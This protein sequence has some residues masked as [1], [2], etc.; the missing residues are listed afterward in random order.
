MDEQ[1][2]PPPP[3]PPATDAYD[4]ANSERSSRTAASSSARRSAFRSTGAPP[5]PAPSFSQFR[6]SLATGKKL[7]TDDS[8][9][10]SAGF[11]SELQVNTTMSSSAA[12]GADPLTPRSR[13]A[14]EK[15]LSTLESTAAQ[16]SAS[17]ARTNAT[18]S[19]A[20]SSNNTSISHG[21]SFYS[22]ASRAD[23]ARLR[24]DGDKLQPPL[25]Q[26]SPH[27]ALMHR[28]DNVMGTHKMSGVTAFPGGAASTLGGTASMASS[29]TNT[30]AYSGSASSTPTSAAGAVAVSAAA[31]ASAIGLPHRYRK[32][33]LMVDPGEYTSCGTEILYNS[34]IRLRL[35]NHQYLRISAVDAGGS[36]TGG[37]HDLPP[38]HPTS[39]EAASTLSATT[40]TLGVVRTAGP[41]GKAVAIDANG[42]GRNGDDDQVFVLVNASLRTDCGEVH[43]SDTVALYCVA[44]SCKGHFLSTD[45]ITQGVTLKKGPVISNNEKWRLVNPSIPAESRSESGGAFGGT[46]SASNSS[47]QD[48]YIS[49]QSASFLWEQQKIIATSDK[50]MLKMN[51]ADVFLS[52]P[53]SVSS[54]VLP[55]VLR[56]ENDG[57]DDVV[58]VWEITKS[59][60]PFDPEWNREREYLT[61]EAFVQPASKR[62]E[63]AGIGSE[64]NLRPLSTLP[65]SVQE[66]IM[67]DELLYAFVGLEGRY[68]KL[69]VTETKSEAARS[70]RSFKFVLNQPGMDPSISSLASRCFRL[71]EFYLQLS[72][73]VEQFSRYEYGQVNHA[74]CAALKVL[75]KEYTIVI[76]Q[77]EHQMKSSGAGQ[78]HHLT[79]QKMWYQIQP[80]MRTM[81]MLSMLVEACRNTLGGGS[82]LTEIQNMMSSLAGDTKARQVFS[83]LMERA[84]VP[85]LKMIE[86]W[87]Y[88]GDLVDPY[89][90]FM[91]RRDDQIGKE[92]VSDNPYS[93][94]WESRYTIRKTQTPRF[95]TRFEQ[96]ILTA[97]KYLNIF[98]TCNRQVDCPF[99]GPI[100]YSAGEAA[101]EEMIDRAHGYASQMLLDLFLKENDLVNRLS[102]IK[103]YFLMDQ[104]DFF[105]DFMHVAEEELK[106]RA[107]KL[108]LSRLE[109]LLHLSL[110]TSTCASDPYKD[111]LVCFLSPHNLI[112]Q[113]E[114]I[115][116]RAQKG[117]RDS[118][119]TFASSSIGH[120]GMFVH[121]TYPAA[122]KGRAIVLMM[123]WCLLT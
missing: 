90:E 51:T 97:G 122:H 67:M 76:G 82:L 71:G 63:L 92:D 26:M 105:V 2:P 36:A 41:H 81:E 33:G 87:I 111:D 38:R 73:Y 68:V 61:G 57:I 78:D 79:M 96:K 99:A 62:R 14:L 30:S 115:H 77:L 106:L 109:S 80:S 50:I 101:Y 12:M 118:L 107:D 121:Q 5:T 47:A 116:Q 123:S 17:S 27:R 72:L 88:H 44:G 29:F 85:Y 39:A 3:P 110:Q 21:G 42:D 86:R 70:S 43:Y 95:L 104:G 28:V 18:A 35:N 19:T 48:P 20:T 102:S 60:V 16:R 94:Y 75:L 55:V 98:R 69:E 7:V 6:A 13:R 46:S 23:A 89:D 58:Q 120:P 45:P 74:L 32:A 24:R 40:S 117:P 34:L 37:H 31:A 93:T 9:R 56:K 25:H 103:H 119:T 108:S 15:T 100:Q 8:V 49:S 59:N 84:S 66:S 112:S 65:P 64:P 11:A 52:V 4:D 113:M 54:S 22:A 1:D 114:A 91:I 83:F 53:P 10:E